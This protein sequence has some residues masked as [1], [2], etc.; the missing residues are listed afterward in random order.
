MDNPEKLAT[1]GTK[2]EEKHN[3]TQYVLDTTIGANTNIVNKT[4]ATNNQ[5]QT[6]IEHRFYAEIVTAITTRNSQCKNT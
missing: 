6:R 5:R 2:D 1:Q 3:T 4:P